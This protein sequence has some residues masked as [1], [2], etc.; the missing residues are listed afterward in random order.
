MARARLLAL[1]ALVL[2][3][4]AVVAATPARAADDVAPVYVLFKAGTLIDGTGAAPRARTSTSW[5]RTAGSRP[6]ARASPARPARRRS[7][8]RATRCCPGSSIATPTSRL[9]PAGPTRPS[10]R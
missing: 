2:A 8:S 7:T 9:E 5:S 1:A 4:S 10:S 3:L 6:S